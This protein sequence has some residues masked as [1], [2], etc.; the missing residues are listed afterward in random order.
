MLDILCVADE[1]ELRGLLADIAEEG[2]HRLTTVARTALLEEL[3][4]SQQY[5]AVI[6]EADPYNKEGVAIPA[7]REVRA[8]DPRIPIVLCTA[9]APATFNGALA[10]LGLEHLRLGEIG[11]TPSLLEILRRIESERR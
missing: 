9:R 8:E 6:W 3:R 10:E 2:G 5:A 1:R 11:F 7:L 4:G